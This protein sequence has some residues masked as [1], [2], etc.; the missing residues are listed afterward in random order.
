MNE[1]ERRDYTLATDTSFTQIEGPHPQDQDPCC[2]EPLSLD[3]EEVVPLQQPVH[4]HVGLQTPFPTTRAPQQDD[5]EA[6]PD[7]STIPVRTNSTGLVTHAYQR[8][9]AHRIKYDLLLPGQ[10]LDVEEHIPAFIHD[11]L[12]LP[13][14]LAQLTDQVQLP[15][16][17]DFHSHFQN[18]SVS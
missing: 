14:S 18:K 3:G 8:A 1:P 10:H 2:G 11:T 13:G 9:L 7:T 5:A 16:S 4:V 15:V 12:M 17:R 6:S